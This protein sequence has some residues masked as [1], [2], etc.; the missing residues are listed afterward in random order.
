M[1][2]NISK[3]VNKLIGSG[4]LINDIMARSLHNIDLRNALN[5]YK[6]K[7]L[8]DVYCDLDF[9]VGN[10]TTKL[11]LSFELKPKNIQISYGK[12][13]WVKFKEIYE[14]LKSNMNVDILVDSIKEVESQYNRSVT[15]NTKGIKKITVLKEKRDNIGINTSISAIAFLSIEE[16][17]IE[18]QDIGINITN[19]EKSYLHNA[20]KGP[21]DYIKYVKLVEKELSKLENLSLDIKNKKLI[22]YLDN[23]KKQLATIKK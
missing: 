22:N 12:E 5:T 7:E 1:Q 9:T 11:L 13:G 15:E 19:A 14:E 17:D 21:N 18:I 10:I 4:P 23:Y 3:I 8:H 2:K 16:E 20:S 6:L